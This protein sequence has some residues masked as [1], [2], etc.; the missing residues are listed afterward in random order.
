MPHKTDLMTIGQLASAAEVPVS[1][2]RYYERADLLTPAGRTEGN[3]RIYA[4]EALGRLRFIRAAQSVG[5]SLDDISRLLGFRTDGGGA[6][7]EVRDLIEG[8]LS[9]LNRRIEDLV[10]LRS[11]LD[12]LL[13]LCRDQEDSEPCQAMD[14][15]S[16]ITAQATDPS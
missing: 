5:F 16:T 12:S 15:L 10:G 13:T 6:C 9:E 7:G 1:T 14:E 2:V 3:Y 8:R 11:T 4:A